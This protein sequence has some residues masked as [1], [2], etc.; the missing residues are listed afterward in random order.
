MFSLSLVVM[1]IVWNGGLLVKQFNCED[2]ED[3]KRYQELIGV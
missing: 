3:D 2:W 1:K